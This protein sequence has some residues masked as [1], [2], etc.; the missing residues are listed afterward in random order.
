MDK[1]LNRGEVL[2]RLRTIKGHVTGIEKMV[3]EGKNCEDILLQ[4]VAVRS[5][6]EKIGLLILEDHSIDC[7]FKEVKDDKARVKIKDVISTIIRFMK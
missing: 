7:L 4:I 1:S 3:E 6:V 2:N 5:S